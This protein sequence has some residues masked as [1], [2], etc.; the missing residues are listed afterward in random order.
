MDSS[1]GHLKAKGVMG[2]VGECF[3]KST[4]GPF[5]CDLPRETVS[6]C[7]QKHIGRGRTGIS[8]KY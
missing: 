3:S 4:L 1:N 5:K 8:G 7:E 2:A 6:A